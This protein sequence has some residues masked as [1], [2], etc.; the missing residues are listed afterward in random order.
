MIIPRYLLTL[1]FIGF[2]AAQEEQ[3]EN[4]TFSDF[5]ISS[6]RYMTNANGNI[7]MYVNVWGQV[8]S[9][10]HKLVYDGIDKATLM[11]LVG[12]PSAGSDLKKVKLFRE[13]PDDDGQIIYI[14]NFNNF[15]KS[16]DRSDFIQIKPNDTIIIEEKLLSSIFRGNNT[17]NSILQLLNIYFEKSGQLVFGENT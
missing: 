4:P 7:L 13:L 3:Q 10:G 8:G 14:L 5:Q 15:L 2:I 17:L 9:P 1:I 11:S 16:G 6:E 12:G